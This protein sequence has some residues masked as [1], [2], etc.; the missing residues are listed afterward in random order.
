MLRA[1]RNNLILYA[2]HTNLDSV[3]GG[4]SSRIADKL[5][6]IN[7]RILVPRENDLVKLVCFI[8]TSHLEAVSQAIFK[9]GAGAIG[10]YDHCSFQVS[11]NGTFRASKG[12]LPICWGF[13]FRT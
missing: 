7:Q 8:P 5:G 6:L 12:S 9:A 3:M 2:C 4:V 1:I 10:K 11:G 13:S